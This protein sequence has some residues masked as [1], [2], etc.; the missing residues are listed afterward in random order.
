[1]C[2]IKYK[3]MYL[4]IIKINSRIIKI[5]HVKTKIIIKK[6]I[7]GRYKGIYSHI[8]MTLG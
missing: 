3:N 4:D 6:Y 5:Q 1:M 8:F 7:I 2:I